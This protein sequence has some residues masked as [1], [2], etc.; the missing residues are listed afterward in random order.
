MDA[1]DG[2]RIVEK[3]PYHAF[4]LPFAVAPV[5]LVIAQIG[6]PNRADFFRDKAFIMERR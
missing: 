6:A 4:K 1:V 3:F 2:K 5:L